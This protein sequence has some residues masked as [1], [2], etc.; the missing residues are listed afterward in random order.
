MLISSKCP[1]ICRKLFDAVDEA[2]LRFQMLRCIPATEWRVH[3]LR[4]RLALA[5]FFNDVEYTTNAP[6]KLIDLSDIRTRLEQPQFKIDKDTDYYELAAMISILDIAIDDGRSTTIPLTDPEAEQEFNTEVDA[7]AARVYIMWSHISDAGASFMSRI[8][9]K[10]VLESLRQRL[11]YA[12]RTKPKPKKGIFDSTS[13]NIEVLK[14]QSEFMKK[15]F[16]KEV[17]GNV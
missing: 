14:K 3:E 15:H 4:R 12:V 17:I 10:E 6:Q 13:D 11:S 2:T 9:A 8:D 16:K 5:F 1:D 7:L